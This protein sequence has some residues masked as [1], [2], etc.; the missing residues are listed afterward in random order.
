MRLR[1]RRALAG[2][3]EASEFDERRGADDAALEQRGE[4]LDVIFVSA[5]EPVCT[6]TR[7]LPP[8]M[9]LGP[10]L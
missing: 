10:T 4:Q 6:H 5:T 7:R 2:G 8:D 3:Q 9:E 1:P